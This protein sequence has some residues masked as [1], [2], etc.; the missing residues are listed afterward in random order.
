VPPAAHEVI[1]Y[2]NGEA[3]D[4]GDAELVRQRLERGVA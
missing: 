1:A 4:V 3:V 2:R